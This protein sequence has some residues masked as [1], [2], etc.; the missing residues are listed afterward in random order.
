MP[1]VQAGA[2]NPPLTSGEGV[3]VCGRSGDPHFY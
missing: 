2:P 3:L 1:P